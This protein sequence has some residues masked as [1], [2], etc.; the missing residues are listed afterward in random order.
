VAHF[1]QTELA[2]GAE[3]HAGTNLAQRITQAV[4]DIAAEATLH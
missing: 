2:D 1:H 3:L 4:F